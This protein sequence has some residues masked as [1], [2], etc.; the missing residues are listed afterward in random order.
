[1][2][3][4]DTCAGTDWAHSSQ[5]GHTLIS[6][7][8]AWQVRGAALCAQT[9]WDLLR[10]AEEVKLYSGSQCVSKFFFFHK[11][12]L[13]SNFFFPLESSGEP[14]PQENAVCV[15]WPHGSPGTL[16]LLGTFIPELEEHNQG[17]RVSIVAAKI[18]VLNSRKSS[19][20]AEI[21][22][23]AAVCGCRQ[24]NPSGAPAGT[25]ADAEHTQGS[26]SGRGAG[27]E[28]ERRVGNRAPEAG[29]G[30][31]GRA[32]EAGAGVSGRTELC[33]GCRTHRCGV[34]TSMVT[35]TAGRGGLQVVV[36]RLSSGCC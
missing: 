13:T 29:D 25:Q 14:T 23:M 22:K 10:H 18:Q 9:I 8:T 24:Q 6:V 35:G 27:G 32:P 16:L 7:S 5:G 4:V 21:I 26:W 12:L 30:V 17:Q 34:C 15:Q 2:G 11:P 33:F 31:S 19:L 1:M 3:W 28:G 20:R 36:R